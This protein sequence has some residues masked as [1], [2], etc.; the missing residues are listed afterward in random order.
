MRRQAARK[1]DLPVAE[2]IVAQ[3]RFD[4]SQFIT[5]RGTARR[6]VPQGPGVIIFL[7]SSPARPR[8][9]GASGSAPPS[10]ASRT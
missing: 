10:G 9:P 6:M 7:T 1:I 2:F 5:A 4:L 8:I 3:T